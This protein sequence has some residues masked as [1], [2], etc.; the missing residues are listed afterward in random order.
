MIA[1]PN[2][3]INL[4]L[5]VTGRRPDGYHNLETFFYPVPLSDMLEVVPGNSFHFRATGLV[6]DAVP[7]KNLVVR[8]YD[9]L[10]KEFDLPP[11]QIHLHKVIPFGAGLGGGSAD[12]AF[13]LKMINE[14]F[15]LGL[16]PEALKSYAA[17]IGADCPFF[18]DNLPAFASGTGNILTPSG[19]NLDDYHLV[20]VKPPYGV[21]TAEAYRSITPRKPAVPLT[22]ILARPADEWKE[23]LVNDFEEPVFSLYPGIRELKERLYRSG[24]VY[25]SMS[26]S[27]SAVFGLFRDKIPDLAEWSGEG[28]FVYQSRLGIL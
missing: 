8:A 21:S 20:I 2:A 23:L 7:D 6:L 9:L 11:V 1:F 3:K 26:G 15:S 13:M 12:A 19:I 24:A 4:G 28:L 10:R 16:T 27:G 5:Q 18:I 14:M 17:G 25:A 22:E